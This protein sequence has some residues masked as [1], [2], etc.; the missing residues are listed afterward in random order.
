MRILTRCA[1]YSCCLALTTAAYKVGIL[2]WML[3]NPVVQ[4]S[5]CGLKKESIANCKKSACVSI[6][7]HSSVIPYAQ[8]SAKAI[9]L[10]KDKEL[11]IHYMYFLVKYFWHLGA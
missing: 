6:H 1:I 2:D 5:I 8:A 7:L 4:T 9:K 10:R 11:V 3:L